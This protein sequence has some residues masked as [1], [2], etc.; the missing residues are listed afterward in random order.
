MLLKLFLVDILVL[1]LGFVLLVGDAATFDI[2]APLLGVTLF[3]AGAINC[4]ITS[5]LYTKTV[6]EG[7]PWRREETEDE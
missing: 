7:R 5:W 2:N 4:A 6:K 3:I 1:L